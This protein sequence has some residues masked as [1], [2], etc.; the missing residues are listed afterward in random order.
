MARAVQRVL[1]IPDGPAAL[2]TRIFAGAR[3]R[4]H[5]GG[6]L[7][8]D[9]HRARHHLRVD[10]RH[11]LRPGRF[12]DAGNVRRLL[13]DDRLRNPRLSRSYAGPIIAALLAGPVVFALDWLVARFIFS[14][15]PGLGPAASDTAAS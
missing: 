13:P 8:A 4:G 14:P 7:R 2:P 9:V 5:G 12:P 3:R 15:S 10:A 6:G 1:G 11:Q